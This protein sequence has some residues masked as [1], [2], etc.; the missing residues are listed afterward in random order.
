MAFISG[1]ETNVFATGKWGRFPT[2]MIVGYT[3]IDPKFQVFDLTTKNGGV[4]EYNVLKYRYRHTF[5]A[6]WDIDFNGFTFGTNWQYFSFLE[7]LD[8]VFNPFYTTKEVGTGMGLGLFVVIRK[9]MKY[10]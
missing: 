5:N 8:K 6:T 3:F 10:G 2:S 7:N 1:I 9:M 4:A